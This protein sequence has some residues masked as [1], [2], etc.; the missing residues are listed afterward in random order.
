[1]S[2]KKA[3]GDWVY[4]PDKINPEFYKFYKSLDTANSTPLAKI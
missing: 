3:G 1:M 2:T 4:S